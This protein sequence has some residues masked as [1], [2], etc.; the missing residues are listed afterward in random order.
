MH[1]AQSNAHPLLA[2]LLWL[3]SDLMKVQVG[4]QGPIWGFLLGWVMVGVG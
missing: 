3:L 4:E 2:P 1:R